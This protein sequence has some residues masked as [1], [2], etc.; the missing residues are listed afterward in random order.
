MFLVS[1]T[2]LSPQKKASMLNG[3]PIIPR[4]YSFYPPKKQFTRPSPSL[5]NI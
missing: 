3:Q 5:E 2:S 4:M 1:M